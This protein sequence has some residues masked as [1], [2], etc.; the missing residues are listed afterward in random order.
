[1]TKPYIP[2]NPGDLITSDNWNNMQINIKDDIGQVR[3]EVQDARGTFGSLSERL[4]NNPGPQG[5]PGPV[6]PAPQHQ[7]ATTRLRFQNPDGTWGSYVD[8]QGPAGEGGGSDLLQWV[9]VGALERKVQIYCALYR[10]HASHMANAR[11]LLALFDEAQAANVDFDPGRSLVFLEVASNLTRRE[12]DLAGGLFADLVSS[13][14]I[15]ES[16]LQAYG[17]AIKALLQQ[18]EGLGAA[19]RPADLLPIAR[20]MNLVSTYAAMLVPPLGLG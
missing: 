6:G 18:I 2:A 11:P 9:L 1:M 12:L 20:G 13:H 15:D 5:D 3:T 8:L 17:K 10:F 19:P 4:D 14:A 7:W 16:R